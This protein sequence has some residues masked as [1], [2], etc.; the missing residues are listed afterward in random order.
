MRFFNYILLFAILACGG[1]EMPTEVLKSDVNLKI[2][3]G[4]TT[5]NNEPY[6]GAIVAYYEG[7]T[8]AYSATYYKGRKQGKE[9]KW[10]A[11]GV[12]ATERFYDKGVKTGLHRGWWE[13]SNR[14]FEFYFDTNGAYHGTVKEWFVDGTLYRDFNYVHG[15]EEGSQKLFKPNGNIRANYVVK[16]GERYGLIGLKNCDPVSTM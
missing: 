11:N 4:V 10:H 1:N 7:E 2:E 5:Y 14:K 3:N 6:S 15:K 13:N 8:L 12:L 9:S 16:N